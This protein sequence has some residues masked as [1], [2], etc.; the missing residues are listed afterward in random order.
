M[1]STEQQN[2]TTIYRRTKHPTVVVSVRLPP[3]LKVAVDERAASDRRTIST[4]F[5]LALENYLIPHAEM[6]SAG[7]R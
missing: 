4:V 6:G 2:S 3:E 1:A 5:A 7:A